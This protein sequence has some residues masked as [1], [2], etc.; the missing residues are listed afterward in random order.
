MCWCWSFHD[1]VYLAT[2]S[3]W[4]HQGHFGITALSCFSCRPAMKTFSIKYF[5]MCTFVRLILMIKLNN[6]VLFMW[7][8]GCERGYLCWLFQGVCMAYDWLVI[9]RLNPFT[10]TQQRNSLV[11]NYC[12]KVGVRLHLWLIIMT[13]SIS[14]W[15][16][17]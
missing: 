13:A 1:K 16:T 14:T 6:A 7:F 15:T 8:I 2:S 17:A 11:Q 10:L 9:A 5:A 4:C 3:H 12:Q